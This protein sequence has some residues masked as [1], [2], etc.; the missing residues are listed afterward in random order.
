[1]LRSHT[2][3]SILEAM[4]SAAMVVYCFDTLQS[5][6]DGGGEP[7]PCFDVQLE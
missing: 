7:T 4:A 3:A 5:H 2:G 6:F 1:M